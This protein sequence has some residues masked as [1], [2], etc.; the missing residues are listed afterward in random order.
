MRILG[1]ERG[2]ALPLALMVILILS[3][4]VA[5][6]AQMTISEVEIQRRTDLDVRAQ[7]LAQAGIEHQIFVLKGNK[8]AGGLAPVNYPPAA[9]QEF[10]YSTA[11]VCQLHCASNRES[12]RWE[13]TATGEVR[14]S[15][16]G[17][18]L[19]TRAIRAIIEIA[20]SGSGANLYQFPAEVTILRWEEVYP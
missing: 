8:D 3:A 18:I 7:Y 13:V 15:G 5:G 14:R 2:V 19:Q 6:V 12:R 16:G 1:N 9:G 4:L 11:L 17:P 20:Y 10:W